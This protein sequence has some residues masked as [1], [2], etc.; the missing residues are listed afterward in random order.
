MK[1]YINQSRGGKIQG[2][3][4]RLVLTEEGTRYEAVVLVDDKN[5]KERN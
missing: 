1:R 3:C 4:H 2:S 5:I